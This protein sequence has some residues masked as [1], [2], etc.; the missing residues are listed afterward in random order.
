GAILVAGMVVATVCTPAGAATV[1]CNPTPRADCA[2][3]ATSSLTIKEAA[4]GRER[5]K[6]A[7]KGMLADVPQSQFGDPVN[8][9][10]AWNVCFSED[11]NGLPGS[12]DTERGGQLC[13]RV[14]RPCWS[15]IGERVYRYKDVTAG[16][17]GVEKILAQGG[18]AGRGRILLKAGN[19]AGKHET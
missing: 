17:D 8:G 12:L 3:P 5:M 7:L 6:L 2:S 1:G 13:G 18:P 15:A 9:T 10:T 11:T 19:A 14:G 4:V 16:A